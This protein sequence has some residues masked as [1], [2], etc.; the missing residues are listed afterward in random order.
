M[1]FVDDMHETQGL[2]E[3]TMRIGAK[4]ENLIFLISQPRSGST[5]VQRILAVHPDIYTTSEPWLMLHPHYALRSDGYRAE[6]NEELARKAMEAFLQVI[7][8]GEDEYIKGVRRMYS[9]LYESALAGSGKRYFLDKTPRYYLIIPELFR[10]FPK[11][12]YIILFRN[13]LAVLCSVLKTWVKEDWF[14]LSGAK[15]DLIRAPRLLLGGLGLLGKGVVVIHYEPLVEN[16][17]GEVKRI[18]DLLGLDF[19]P[20]MIEYGR[21]N[22][23]HWSLGD[24]EG[25]YQHAQPATENIQKWVK[26]LADPQVWRLANDYLELL[27]NEIVEEIGYPY[28]ELRQLLEMHRP[29]RVSPRLTFPLAW[30]LN[31]PV[32]G[33]KRWMCGVSTLMMLLRTR[34]VRGTAVAVMRGVAYALSSPE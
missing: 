7:P 3:K 6:Y 18:C 15:N 14:S 5:L 4:G 9:Y 12:R 19:V 2:T 26:M 16:P 21:L 33:P 27:G 1:Q 17:G 23:P 8:K 31:E 32:K 20:E 29:R 13:P 25:I 28:Q 24:A 11:A 30:L 34:G 10:T 22:L